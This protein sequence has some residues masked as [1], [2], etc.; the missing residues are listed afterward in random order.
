[1][2]MKRP[3]KRIK[4]SKIINYNIYTSKPEQL[5]FGLNNVDKIAYIFPLVFPGVVDKNK[6]KR[7][8]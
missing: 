4:T 2:L 6:I 5:F 7:I 3:R 8:P 1:M